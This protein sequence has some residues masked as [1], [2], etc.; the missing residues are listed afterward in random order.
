MEPGKNEGSQGGVWQED[1]R[2]FSSACQMPMK[3]EE[4]AEEET[5][6]SPEWR[7]GWQCWS[8][9]ERPGRKYLPI[10][11]WNRERVDR[12]RLPNECSRKEGKEERDQEPRR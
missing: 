9:E 11:V 3:Q 4:E 2:I 5:G 10:I 12:G 8:A 6:M 1:W 7:E